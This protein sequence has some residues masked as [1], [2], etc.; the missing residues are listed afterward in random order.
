M[1]IE[2]FGSYI[3]SLRGNLCLTIVGNVHGMRGGD[4]KS[5]EG[6]CWEGGMKRKSKRVGENRP[7]L[8]EKRRRK[9]KYKKEKVRDI[10][11]RRGMHV[12]FNC[13]RKGGGMKIKQD[14]KSQN[15]MWDQRELVGLLWTPKRSTEHK[16]LFYLANL[17]QMRHGKVHSATTS[18]SSVSSELM[19]S[20]ND[21][22]FSVIGYDYLLD[23]WLR[24][25]TAALTL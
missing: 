7:W 17:F 12:E 11:K 9:E 13:W 10:E 16:N 14:H 19:K 1:G 5:A 22:W 24:A 21:D 23:S 4:R 18:W 6:V 15:W 3:H 2:T 8:R 20:E 25:D